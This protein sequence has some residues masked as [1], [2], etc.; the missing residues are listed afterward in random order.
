VQLSLG[1]NLLF[2]QEQIK[3]IIINTHVAKNT[4]TPPW[5]CVHPSTTHQPFTRSNA[6]K[7]WSLSSDM[8]AGPLARVIVSVR[9]NL[10]CRIA[11]FSP[12]IHNCPVAPVV[13]SA[14]ADPLQLHESFD[15]FSESSPVASDGVFENALVSFDF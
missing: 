5:R 13:C 11:F 4:V 3:D 8:I 9:A 15:L 2:L 6:H 7:R 1:H 10:H 14:H 12:N